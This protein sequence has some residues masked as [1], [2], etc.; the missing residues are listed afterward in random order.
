[1]PNVQMLF[2]EATA[3]NPNGAR[4]LPADALKEHELARGAGGGGR[5]R[6]KASNATAH[7]AALLDGVVGPV[8]DGTPMLDGIVGP[9]VSTG[10]ASSAGTPMLDGIVGPVVGRGLSAGTTML[11]GIV[12]P[13]VARTSSAPALPPPHYMQSAPQHANGTGHLPAHMHPGLPYPT[14]MGMPPAPAFAQ[15]PPPHAFFG[16]PIATP[17][18][19]IHSKGGVPK[20]GRGRGHYVPPGVA[21]VPAA[22]G[23]TPGL[24]NPEPPQDMMA[25]LGLRR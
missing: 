17:P 25:L 18:A 3:K 15:M 5:G 14:P 24:G 11:D 20:G 4:P 13:V 7:A 1:V 19:V 12:G 16:A 23:L 22:N 21:P 9:V 8:V 6:G 10:R 2:K